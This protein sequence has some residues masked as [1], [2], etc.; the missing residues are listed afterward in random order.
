MN[1]STSPEDGEPTSFV[2]KTRNWYGKHRTTIRAVG[3]AVGSVAAA[4]AV[5]AVRRATEQNVTD[6]AEVTEDAG[7]ASAPE[8][9]GEGRRPA[10]PHVRKLPEGWNA[11]EQKKARYKEETGDDLAPGTTYVNPPEDEDPGEAAA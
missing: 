11:S 4:V 8:A 1:D 2:E 7:P 10:S 5:V 6:A 9:T 3:G